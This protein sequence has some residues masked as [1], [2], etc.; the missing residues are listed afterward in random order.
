VAKGSRAYEKI[1]CVTKTGAFARD[2]RL[3]S[4]IQSAAVSI[5]SNV[6]KGFERKRSS[7]FHQFLSIA[8][9]SCAEVRSILYV[10]FDVEHIDEDTFNDVRNQADEVGRIIGAL[11]ASI[12]LPLKS[13]PVTKDTK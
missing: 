13:K 3:A 9:A 5:M 12:E 6:A 11:R 7:E 4:Q 8:K 2:F 1:Y 10:A